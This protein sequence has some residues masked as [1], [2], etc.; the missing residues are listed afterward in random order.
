MECHAIEMTKETLA[1]NLSSKEDS[2]SKAERPL[3]QN[4]GVRLA[5]SIFSL[6]SVS[7]GSRLKNEIVN[8]RQ[9]SAVPSLDRR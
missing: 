6:D 5:N 9:V 2:D 1:V 7:I 4:P 3:D 8:Q